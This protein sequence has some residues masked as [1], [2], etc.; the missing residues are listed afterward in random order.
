MLR[1]E[2]YETHSSIRTDTSASR[3]SSKTSRASRQIAQNATTIS[4]MNCSFEFI[5]GLAIFSLLFAC[6]IAPKASTL[7]MM[8]FVVP[9]GITHIPVMAQGFGVLFFFLLLV[10]GLTSSVSLVEAVV[11]SI[12]DKFRLPRLTVMMGVFLTGLIGSMMFALPQVIDPSLNDDGTLGFSLLDMFDHW[13]FGYGL[14]ICGLLE[15]II[16][17]WLYDL[18]KL[19]A[20]IN[21]SA[22]FKLGGFRQ[23]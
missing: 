4:L 1:S 20:F 16:L 14:L 12:I 10:A 11:V 23:I 6:A 8:F 9:E 22:R 2:K 15:V 3:G 18:Q 13:T 7:S 19:V 5:A 17:G 21:Q